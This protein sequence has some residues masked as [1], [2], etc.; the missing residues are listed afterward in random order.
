MP[1]IVGGGEMTF[2]PWT[3]YSETVDHSRICPPYSREPLIK[4]YG[5]FQILQKGNMLKCELDV[6]IRL[7]PTWRWMHQYKILWEPFY[8]KN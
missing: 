8:A 6:R 3:V 4:H 2:G 5:I 7:I 1:G